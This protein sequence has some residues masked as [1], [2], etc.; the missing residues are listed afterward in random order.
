MLLRSTFT[1]LFAIGFGL[2]CLYLFDAKK[3]AEHRHHSWDTW[4]RN[5]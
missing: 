5:R 1:L 2:Y 4:D 3:S